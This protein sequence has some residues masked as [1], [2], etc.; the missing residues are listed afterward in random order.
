MVAAMSYRLLLAVVGHG[1]SD[2]DGSQD[3]AH[4]GRRDDRRIEKDGSRVE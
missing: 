1:V 4:Y 3:S 2:D